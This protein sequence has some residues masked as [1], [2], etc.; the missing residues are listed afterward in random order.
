MFL[1]GGSVSRGFPAFEA[2]PWR[3]DPVGACRAARELLASERS[4]ASAVFTYVDSREPAEAGELLVRSAEK[5]THYKWYLGGGPT[6]TTWLHEYKQPEVFA[7]NTS[8]AAS[9]HNHRYAFAS[10]VLTG[11]MTVRMY[12]RG[13]DDSVTLRAMLALDPGESS[14]L[15]ADDV[16]EVC[17]VRP[18]TYTLVVQGPAQ[19]S[20][21]CVWDARGTALRRIY[22]MEH[23]LGG[24]RTRALGPRETIGS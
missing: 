1:T 2:L 10:L 15:S 14:V 3:L 24:L 23:L 19:R 4:A 11:G 21:S 8:Y 7:R 6:Y 18:N 12:D 13:E 17:S 22:D 20:Y 5:S 9:I 16:H